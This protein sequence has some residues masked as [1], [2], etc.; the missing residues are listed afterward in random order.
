MEGLAEA[1]LEGAKGDALAELGDLL[2]ARGRLALHPRH[3][4]VY[5]ALAQATQALQRARGEELD[6]RLTWLWAACELWAL[7]SLRALVG[8]RPFPELG[9][10]LV[11]CG[12]ALGA[13]RQAGLVWGQGLGEWEWP[14][15]RVGAEEEDPSRLIGE[16]IALSK[17]ARG[18]RK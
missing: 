16:G 13:F 1:G 18:G 3:W 9:R 11:S 10:R 2:F 4:L 7:A 6:T 14:A 8:S 17:L 5:Q 15:G 12:R